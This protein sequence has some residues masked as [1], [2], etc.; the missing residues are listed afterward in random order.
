MSS[1][2]GQRGRSAG[3][4]A[5]AVAAGEARAADVVDEHLRRILELD[6]EVAAFL[7]VFAD[8]ARQRAERLDRG[9]ARGDRMGTLAGVPVAYKD[10]LVRRGFRTTCA[11]KI[12]EGFVSPYTATALRK[13]E[14]EGAVLI[15]RTNMDEF[16]M[17]S[18]T[19]HSAFGPTRNPRDLARVPGGSSG[20]SAAAVAAGMVPAALGSDTGGSIRQPAAFCGVVGLKPTYGRVSRH[21][22]VAYAS[23]LDAVGTLARCAADNDL[24]L[25]CISGQ[26]DLDSTSLP[27]PAP[28]AAGPIGLQGLR[29]GVPAEAFDLE[30]DADVR[31]AVERALARLEQAGARRVPVGLPNLPHAIPVYYLIATAEASSNLARYDGVKFGRRSPEASSLEELYSRTRAEGFGGEV[32]RRIL[33]GTYCL[34]RGYYD[35]YYLKATKVRTLIRR[36]FEAALAQCDVLLT[37]TTPTT[38]FRLGQ[39][40]HDPL[41]MYASDVLT[42]AVNLAGLPAISVPC[43][44]SSQGLPVGMQLIAAPLREDV[45]LGVAAAYEA[46]E[47]QPAPLAKEGRR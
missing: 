27:S 28:G 1:M 24:L 32:K 14:D 22:L 17:G 47:P 30:L 40:L 41:A 25:R 15:G 21:G 20:G 3:A 23:S 8:D 46:I 11:S 31:G 39:K 18:S 44:A 36:D 42:V 4:I 45:L 35:A 37:P 16:A 38:A 12:L 33:L 34:R 10:N 7:E 13:L 9:R 43:G 6:T 2:D 29:V 26:D 19:E 5:A